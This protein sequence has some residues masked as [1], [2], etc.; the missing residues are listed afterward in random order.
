MKSFR[1]VK[2]DWPIPLDELIAR[3]DQ[4]RKIQRKLV[5]VFCVLNSLLFLGFGETL[6]W[7]VPSV[8]SDP[9]QIFTVFLLSVIYFCGSYLLLTRRLRK[10]KKQFGLQ[11]PE[12]HELLDQ[13]HLMMPIAVATGHCASC[14]TKLVSR[15]P[16][17]T[18]RGRSDRSQAFEATKSFRDVKPDWPIPLIEW[19]ARHHQ[20]MKLQ[21]KL[22]L[23]QFAINFPLVIGLLPIA[24]WLDCLFKANNWIFI[25]VALLFFIYIIRS[26]TLLARRIEEI[27]KQFGLQC[28]GCNRFLDQSDMQ[29]PIAL[30]TGQCSSCGT[31]LISDH[32]SQI[33]Q[34][35]AQIPPQ[36]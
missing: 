28:P 11:C 34:G 18:S 24:I 29:M 9:W 10:S 7:L 22:S 23:R 6:D 20:S 32:P 31:K 5:T 2:P 25:P 3:R 1:D 21:S 35:G 30:A 17:H 12:C 19:I 14:G 13:S 33:G 4:H 16:S 26:S 8:I 15:P 27:Q 36:R